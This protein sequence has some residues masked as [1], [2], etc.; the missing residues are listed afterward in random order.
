MEQIIQLTTQYGLQILL[1][2]ITLSAERMMSAIRKWAQKEENAED[3]KNKIKIA[4]IAVGSIEQMYRQLD[5]PDKLNKAII[6]ASIR[7]QEKGI[8]VTDEEIRDLIEFAVQEMNQGLKGF[9]SEYISL[10]APTIHTDLEEE[11]K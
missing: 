1:L 10:D 2:V 11:I 7:F 5:G 3:I 6:Q 8:P 4:K 9:E